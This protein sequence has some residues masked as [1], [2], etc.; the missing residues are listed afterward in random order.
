MLILNPDPI[1]WILNLNGNDV[2]YSPYFQSYLVLNYYSSFT[3][4][5]LFID[6]RKVSEDIFSYLKLIRIEV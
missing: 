4:G 2:K 5:V 6:K 3:G 1:S